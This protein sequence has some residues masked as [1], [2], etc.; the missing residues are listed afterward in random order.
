[1]SNDKQVKEFKKPSFGLSVA[2]LG[3]QVSLSVF[4]TND[5]LSPH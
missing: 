2:A 1:M 3:S 4:L 5:I